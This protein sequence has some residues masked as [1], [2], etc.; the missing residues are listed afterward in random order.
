MIQHQFRQQSTSGLFAGTHGKYNSSSWIIPSYSKFIERATL[1]E[2]E[3]KQKATNP[4]RN[5]NMIM[6]TMSL[7]EH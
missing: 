5:P 1:H 3:S 7:C 4:W 2:H 6:P